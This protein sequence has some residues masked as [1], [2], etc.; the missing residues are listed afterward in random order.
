MLS[1]FTY[2]LFVWYYRLVCKAKKTPII[3]PYL[4]LQKVKKVVGSHPLQKSA[5]MI[6]LYTLIV[7]RIFCEIPSFLI[8]CR[9]IF[10]PDWEKKQISGHRSFGQSELRHISFSDDANGTLGDFAS[11][12][13]QW[14]RIRVRIND[15]VLR[16]PSS[17]FDGLNVSCN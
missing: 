11:S 15:R 5:H 17:H 1:I 14:F 13:G 7:R 6:R 4:L 12:V 16:C 10:C 9:R 3:V 2:S 8:F